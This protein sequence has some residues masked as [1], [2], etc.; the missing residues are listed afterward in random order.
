MADSLAEAR[1]QLS[2]ANR[3]LSHEGVIDAF[4]H[5]SMRHPTNPDRYLI[6]RH[7]AAELVEPDD[8]LEL[9]LDSVPVKPTTVRLYGEL[10]IH[11]CIYQARPDV[12][13]VCHHHSDSIMPYCM[14][15]VELQPVYHIGASLGPKVPIW[16]SR[17]EF[18]DTQLVVVKP[19]EGRSLARGLGPHWIVLMRHHG[20]TVAGTSLIDTVYRTIYTSRN[21]ELQSR[22]L[23]LG[24]VDPLSQGERDK[25]FV[26]NQQPRPT[27]RAWE[28]WTMRVKKAEALNAMAMQ[29]LEQAKMSAAKSRG[30]AKKTSKAKAKR[31]TTTAG[32][33]TRTA[34][35]KGRAAKRPA[36]K[37]RGRR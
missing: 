17:D 18:G 31:K 14:T 19:E 15:D 5:V 23:A 12:M 33:K 30:A 8:V 28:Y 29:A 3:I 6:S 27:E 1:E 4:G 35:T 36:A 25:C 34:K 11:A 2:L 32:A 22:A 20:A 9:T 21:A 26:F 16:D 37:S 7:R 10:V 13:A 24:K